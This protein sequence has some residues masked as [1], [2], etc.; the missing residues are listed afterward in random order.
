MPAEGHKGIEGEML[1]CRLDFSI[2]QAQIRT[3]ENN[4]DEERGLQ[5]YFPCM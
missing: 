5:I 3:G 1:K 2:L 4:H